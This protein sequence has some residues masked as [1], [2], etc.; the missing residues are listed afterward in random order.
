MKKIIIS[1]ALLIFLTLSAH[2]QLVEQ[3]NNVLLPNPNDSK[4]NVCI[5][6]DLSG[7]TYVI[8]RHVI[9][10]PSLTEN[11]YVVSY[12]G[13]G[14]TRFSNTKF[15]TSMTAS[16]IDNQYNTY[17]GSKPFGEIYDPNKHLWKVDPN[18]NQI[19][20]KTPYEEAVQIKADSAG[21]AYVLYGSFW[22]DRYILKY[23]LTGNILDSIYLLRNRYGTLFTLENN[24]YIVASFADTSLT[25]QYKLRVYKVDL[26]GSVIWQTLFNPSG[27]VLNGINKITSLPNGNIYV[28]ASCTFSAT[29]RDY[30]LIKYNSSGVQQW[31]AN[32]NSGAAANDDPA[33]MLID[34]S[35]NIYIIGNT[36]T[37]KYNSSGTFIW[38][39]DHG[40]TAFVLDKNNNLYTVTTSNGKIRTAKISTDGTLLWTYDYTS[41]FSYTGDGGNS[42]AVDT[43]SNIYATGYVATPEP[44]G[45]TIK[46][47]ELPV[48]TVSG[49]I[50]YQDNQQLVTSG[51]VKALKFN[52][53]TGIITTLDSAQI[54]SNGSY[55]LTHVP[56]DTVDVMAFENDE[57][58]LSF[59]PTYYI[60]TIY[61]ENSV[62]I[63][64]TGN[65]TN[66][67]IGVFRINSPAPGPY[68]VGGS[69]FC[70]GETDLGTL[71]DA[72]IY[73]KSGNLFKGYSVS[74]SG[75]AYCI[76][77]LSSANYEIICNRM[78]YY[79]SIRPIQ[80]TNYSMDTID[81]TLSNLIVKIED[82]ANI[83][84][85]K[86]ALYQNY[87]NPFN[88]ATK[89]KF[90]VPADGKGQKA[91]VKLIIYN[92][93]GQQI[94]VLVNHQLLPGVYETEWDASGYSSGIYFYKLVSEDYS[95]TRKMVLIK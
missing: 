76:D 38:R 79:S 85:E 8:G 51:Y 81:F 37:V 21:N 84:P 95:E 69:I 39:Q 78:G 31:Y 43:S 87:P 27:T 70:S 33:D 11:D 40:R 61:W 53:S 72:I 45:I 9:F 73:A 74:L 10:G 65:L 58:E 47:H 28:C 6:A 14:S 5:K 63:Y 16:Y 46:Y 89:I 4:K 59:V 1:S 48:Y 22:I 55:I 44:A 92:P 75:G 13:N 18:G 54:Q 71:K 68:H 57:E 32:F 25:T 94:S 19:W 12:T 77:S 35:E 60:S 36:S 66:I 62:K 52:Y 34:N 50:R 29:G 56:Q 2:S 3:W 26:S 64:P 88:P 20:E 93:L 86:F 67:D 17:I 91:D 7:N 90:S 80:I 30:T 23:G 82:P 24:G 41:T 49:T 42:I 15:N 83:I